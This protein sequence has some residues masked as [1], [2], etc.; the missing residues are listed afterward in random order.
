MNR[1]NMGALVVLLGLLA[2][3]APASA[4]IK[5][6]AQADKLR[7][8]VTD[9]SPDDGVAAAIDFTGVPA[10]DLYATVNAR[11][12]SATAGSAH[13]TRSGKGPDVILLDP[14]AGTHLGVAYLGTGIVA[15][16]S[17]VPLPGKLIDS[18]VSATLEP[19]N[20]RLAPHTRVTFSMDMAIDLSS[21]GGVIDGEGQT[22]LNASFHEANGGIVPLTDGL[23]AL[24]GAVRMHEYIPNDTEV[25]TATIEWDN[26]SDAWVDGQLSYSARVDGYLGSAAP[27]PEPAEWA[28]LLAGA[29][30]LCVR[31]RRNGHMR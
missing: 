7:Y 14:W 10:H 28:L 9:L 31:A 15:A 19:W 29:G 26:D 12:G 3:W 2:P 13:D 20:F 8:T 22:L 11:A 1:M 17:L 23:V 4:Q 27:V 18:H 21:L 16:M 30:V 24:I 5:L 25:R 6:A